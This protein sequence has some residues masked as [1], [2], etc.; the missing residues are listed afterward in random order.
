VA[1]ACFGG[2]IYFYLASNLQGICSE[3]SPPQYKL[4]NQTVDRKEAYGGKTFL[5]LVVS[6][7]LGD[8]ISSDWKTTAIFRYAHFG[9]YGSGVASTPL[10]FEPADST[11]QA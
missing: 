4:F 1:V 6:T 7:L 3:L 9:F 5:S 2:T 10:N 11:I 8:F